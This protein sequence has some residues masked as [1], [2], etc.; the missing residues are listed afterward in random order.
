MQVMGFPS[1]FT[2]WVQ[3]CVCSAKFSVIINGSLEGY[4]QGK[5]GLRQGDPISPYLFLIVMEAFT[6]LLHYRVNQSPSYHPKCMSINLT[7]LVFADDL[8]F[9]LYG[10]STISFQLIKQ[11][12]DDFYSYSVVSSLT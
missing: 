6:A 11:L 10:A 12:L 2:Y 1:R 4:F 7:H 5:R 9:I 3:Q 8:L